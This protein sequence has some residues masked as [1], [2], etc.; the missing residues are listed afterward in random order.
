VLCQLT[1]PWCRE[2]EEEE[3]E[4]AEEEEEEEMTHKYGIALGYVLLAPFR[5]ELQYNFVACYL[6]VI[7]H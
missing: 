5:L 1:A 3:E 4:E 2:E 7:T 6:A